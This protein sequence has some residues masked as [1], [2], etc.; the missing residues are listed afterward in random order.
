MNAAEL[1]LCGDMWSD[2][3]GDMMADHM[4]EQDK[5]DRNMGGSENYLGCVCF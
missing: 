2:G 1:H 5:Q 4:M 3:G